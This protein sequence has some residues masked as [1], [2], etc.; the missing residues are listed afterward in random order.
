M[1]VAA[2]RVGPALVETESSVRIPAHWRKG[3]LLDVRNFGEFYEV[4]LLHEVGR[5]RIVFES[6]A[7]C[8]NFVSEWYT[9]QHH[10]P[11]AG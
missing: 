3:M 8:Q 9:P 2:E 11:R 7:D 5:E 10:D 4:G 1:A 6:G